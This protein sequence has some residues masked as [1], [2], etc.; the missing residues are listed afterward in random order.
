MFINSLH[1][2]PVNTL[3]FN[4]NV[5]LPNYIDHLLEMHNMQNDQNYIWHLALEK[6]HS[7]IE[8]QYFDC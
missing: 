2:L 4:Q 1:K 6:Y 8:N 5:E 3:H 7:Y